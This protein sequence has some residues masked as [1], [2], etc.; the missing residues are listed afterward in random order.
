MPA[1]IPTTTPSPGILRPI[2]SRDG[3]LAFIKNQMLMVETAPRNGDFTEIAQFVNDGAWSPDGLKLAFFINDIPDNLDNEN[4]SVWEAGTN[5][6]TSLGDIV[7]DFPPELPLL[8]E[9]NNRVL[10]LENLKWSPNNESISFTVWDTLEAGIGGV[11]IADFINANFNLAVQ[12]FS[13]YQSW[14]INENTVLVDWH[15]G[16]PCEGLTAYKNG[17]LLWELPWQTAGQF[18]LSLNNE[19]L[20]NTGRIMGRE[21]FATVEE[22]DLATGEIKIIWEATEQG[23]FPLF[24]TNLSP[25]N[26]FIS[27]HFGGSDLWLDP[28]NLYI[29]DRNGRSYGQRPNSVIMDWRPGGGPVVQESVAEGQT[30][31]VYW[32]LDGEAVRVFVSPNSFVFGEGKWSG[33]GRFFI[34]SA[35]DEAENKSYLYLWQS[36]ND[37]PTLLHSGA[38][39][40]GFRNFAWLPDSTGVYF[41]LGQMELWKFEVETKSPTLIA[42]SAE[43]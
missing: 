4:V 7:S 27:F 29:I 14:W 5:T 11:W 38:G 37:A 36:E 15:C 9:G 39:T 23:Y 8:S 40:D 12:E 21:P 32:P 34:Y 18:A 26:N 31:L 3:Q 17:E 24:S 43:D 13:T 6:I 33:D 41:N 16:S 35:V 42:S 30:Q 19:F 25:D 2:L 22:I 10:H 1:Q 20:I 28:G